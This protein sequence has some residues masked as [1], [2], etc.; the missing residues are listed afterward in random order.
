MEISAVGWVLRFRRWLD[1]DLQ[2]QYASLRNMLVGVALNDT[3]DTPKWKFTKSKPFTVNSMYKNSF[4]HSWK[5]RIPL[6]IKV[7]FR[8]IWHNA[9]ATKHNMKKKSGL[10]TILVD[11]VLKM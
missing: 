10:V 5:V 6:M 1:V 3:R 9:T 7:W 2:Q 8:L 11:F 4:K